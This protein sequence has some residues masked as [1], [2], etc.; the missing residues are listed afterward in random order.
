ML[1][2]TCWQVR[3]RGVRLAKQ[4]QQQQQQQE[5]EEDSPVVLSQLQES[6]PGCHATACS[7]QLQL[8]LPPLASLPPSPL[9]A[10][11]AR[12]WWRLGSQR[13]SKVTEQQ[14]RPLDCAAG[15]AGSMQ[16][17]AGHAGT[18]EEGWEHD[19]NCCKGW[20]ATHRGGWEAH[21]AMAAVLDS[22]GVALC[23]AVAGHCS[24][25]SSWA[26]RGRGPCLGRVHPWPRRVCRPSSPRFPVAP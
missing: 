4:H 6:L 12:C 21:I 20:H 24:R 11:R 16:G 26:A 1:D 2:G 14:A 9:P 5:E 23:S 13:A 3:E 15:G 22:G 25:Y 19:N 8:H 18:G 10:F 7:S 17:G